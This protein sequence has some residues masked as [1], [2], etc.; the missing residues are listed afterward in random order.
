MLFP[1]GSIYST[2][3]SGA[4]QMTK[5]NNSTWTSGVKNPNLAGGKPARDLNSGLPWT[6]PAQGG[7]GGTQTRGLEITSPAL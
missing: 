3:A 1:L 4:E 6:N 5:T 2:N 7:Q